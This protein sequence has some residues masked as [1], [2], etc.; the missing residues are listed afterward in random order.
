[1]A[2]LVWTFDLTP[3]GEIDDSVDT[4]YFGGFLICP[5][6]FPLNMK[7]RSTEHARVI[8]RELEEVKPFLA[9]FKE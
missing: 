4:G 6:E 5:K 2:K 1:M 3:A 8:E 9:R 7:S